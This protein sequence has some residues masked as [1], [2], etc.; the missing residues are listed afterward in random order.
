[1]SIRFAF[2]G[3]RHYHI[4]ELYTF[5]RECEDVSIT[6]AAEDDESEARALGLFEG[7][8]EEGLCI[9]SVTGRGLE[10]LR[11][12]LLELAAQVAEETE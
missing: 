5:A 7:M 12:L 1:M 8:G 6:A 2:A 4:D 9:S 3:F 11:R 10:E